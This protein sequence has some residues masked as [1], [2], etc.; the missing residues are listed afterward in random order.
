MKRLKETGNALLLHKSLRQRL[1]SG[2]SL[3]SRQLPKI[4]KLLAERLA[5]AGVCGMCELAA[6]DARR[7]E[8]LTQR[9]Y[10]FGVPAQRM[11]LSD[12]IS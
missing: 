2:S 12:D 10:P 3:Y 6:L 7:I 8:A 11:Q 1:W 4:G 9:N 5:V